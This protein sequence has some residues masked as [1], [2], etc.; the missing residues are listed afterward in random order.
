MVR[1]VPGFVF[2]CWLAL[3]PDND[4][5]DAFK[6]SFVATW[7]IVSPL[8]VAVLPTNHGV[9]GAR[10]RLVMSLPWSVYK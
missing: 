8:I 2:C 5:S 10:A 1:T 4:E 7:Y 6:Y 9:L 3:S